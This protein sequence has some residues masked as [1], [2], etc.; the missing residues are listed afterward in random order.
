MKY[1]TLKNRS[2][3]TVSGK[4]RKLFLQR[5]LTNDVTKV[6]KNNSIYCCLL[7]PQG[8]F[9]YDFF[10]YED[11]DELLLDCNQEQST[12]IINK[13]SLYKLN[14]NV[15]LAKR[16]DLVILSILTNSKKN[17]SNIANLIYPDPRNIK[18]GFRVIVKTSELNNISLHD[19]LLKENVI[20]YYDYCRIYLGII[21]DSDLIFNKSFI[22]EYN[23]N[24]LNAVDYNKGC[25]IGQEVT[26]RTY[27]KGVIRKKICLVKFNDLSKIEKGESIF[28]NEK[29]IGTILSSVFYNQK[30][31]ALAIVKKDVQIENNLF[32]INNRNSTLEEFKN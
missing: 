24:K 22:L 27:Y 15:F 4:D 2:I 10:I 20:N 28:Y 32:K 26:A 8:R 1:I 3:I 6:S 7:N 23:F 29:K 21:D 14:S 17:I 18:M 12:E 5:L 25:Y 13:L 31:L 19:S 11:N 30:L 16:E 9:L